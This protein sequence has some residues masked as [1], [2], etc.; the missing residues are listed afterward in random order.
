MIFLQIFP[1]YGRQYNSAEEVLKDFQNG[2]DF[3]LTKKGGPYFS[4]RDLTDP[5][6]LEVDGFAMFTDDIPYLIPM[7]MLNDT[8]VS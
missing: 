7:A 3:S 2:K 8:V 5:M 4:I 1:A 6:F